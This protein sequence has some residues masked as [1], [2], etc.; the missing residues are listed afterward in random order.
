ML[1]FQRNTAE[2]SQRVPPRLKSQKNHP[3]RSAVVR[4]QA[5]TKTHPNVQQKDK[6]AGKVAITPR[7]G[8]HAEWGPPGNRNLLWGSSQGLKTIGLNLWDSLI[9]ENRNIV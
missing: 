3:N 9:S 6:A 7:A 2:R 5:P 1:T 4:H 8:N